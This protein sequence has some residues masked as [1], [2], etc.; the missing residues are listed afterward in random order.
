MTTEPVQSPA[1]RDTVAYIFLILMVLIGSTTA[2]SAKK[3][4]AE[5]PLPIVPLIRFF[6]A[7]V[8]LLPLALRGG[9]LLR[10][11]REEPIRLFGAALFAVGL[12]Q[13][14]FL[15]GARLAPTTHVGIIYAT[16]P[17][18]VLLI[19]VAIGQERM[20]IGRL[21][22][23]IASVFGVVTIG[24]GNLW[25]PNRDSAGQV[26]L[27]D[28]LLVGAVLTWGAYMTITRPLARRHGAIPTL[29]GTF[30]VGSIIDLP[31]LLLLDWEAAEG[32]LA[33]STIADASWQAWYGLAHL[34]L[35][36]TV[37]ALGCQNL[38]LQRL[39]ASEV[40]TFGNLGPVLTVIWGALFN[41][42]A[43]TVALVLGGI[44]TIGGILWT[45]RPSHRQV[46]RTSRSPS[47]AI[48]TPIEL[49]S[50]TTPEPLTCA[51]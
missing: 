51:D 22:G 17:M 45:L 43:I 23:V 15:T 42:E 38:A 30:L 28:L 36:V 24:I 37:F 13:L 50:R 18:I 33:V 39:D 12:N 34:T 49:P 26:G 35:I 6:V 14:F 41:Q 20:R 9:A 46:P 4:V 1:R 5:L 8:C 16:N 48:S 3:A 27:G 21:P 47:T 31:A 7:G 2:L 29:C 25:G 19:A 32:P 11:I 44:L 40:A 10:L